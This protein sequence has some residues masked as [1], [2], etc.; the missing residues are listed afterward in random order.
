MY[1]YYVYMYIYNF[2]G[3]ALSKTDIK[4]LPMIINTQYFVVCFYVCKI[5]FKKPTHSL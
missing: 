4:Y 3:K 5:F 1:T 2:L